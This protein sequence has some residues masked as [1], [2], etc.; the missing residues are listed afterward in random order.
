MITD[1]QGVISA[2]G[3]VW[4]TL[5]NPTTDLLTKTND[6]S[7]SGGFTSSITSLSPG[8]TYYLR[9]YATNANGTGYGNQVSFITSSTSVTIGTQIWTIANLDVATY[10]DGV[11]IPQVTDPAA[12]ALLTTG[13]WCYYNN[14][15]ANGAVYGKLYNWYAVAGIFDAASL[16][17]PSLRKQLAPAG[18]HIPSDA[19]WSTLTTFLGGEN[20]AGGKMKETGTIH[21]KNPNT[22]ATNS[23]GFNGLPGGYRYYDGSFGSIVSDGIWWSST[24]FNTTNAWL[25]D[26]SYDDIGAD[27]SNGDKENGFSVRCLKD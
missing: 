5:Q 18:Y 25:R 4:S 19:E 13:A 10:R 7:G 21:W 22:N 8:T 12:W 6:G 17:N 16:L 27:R 2:K 3:V 24:E 14:D 15:P 1:A 9:A 26:I 23:S 20:L 11:P